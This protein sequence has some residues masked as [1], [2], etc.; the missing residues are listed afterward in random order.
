MSRVRATKEVATRRYHYAVRVLIKV[1]LLPEGYREKKGHGEMV[2]KR[3]N[4]LNK[5][6]E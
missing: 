5:H 1:T 3:P 6:I 4:I 2:Q